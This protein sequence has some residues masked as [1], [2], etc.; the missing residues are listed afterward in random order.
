M[1]GVEATRVNVIAVV[2][3]S[4]MEI[5]KRESALGIYMIRLYRRMYTGMRQRECIP[6]QSH[7]DIADNR[8]CMLYIF[9]RLFRW[10]ILSFVFIII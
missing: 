4:Y 7:N 1:D 2:T 8:V 10:R 6:R 5:K 9:V 3:L